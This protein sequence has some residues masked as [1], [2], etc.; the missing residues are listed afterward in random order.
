MSTKTKESGYLIGFLSISLLILLL[1]GSFLNE[2][3]R[4][5]IVQEDI[6]SIFL[7]LYIITWGVMFL[8]SYYFSHKS[9]FF[10]AIIWV[11]NSMSYPSTPK[12]AIFYSFLAF[13]VG[14]VYFFEAVGFL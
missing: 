12:M 3:P 2:N 8:M 5:G 14:I 6:G 13:I 4:N 10:R 11:C 9:F 1:L 7:S